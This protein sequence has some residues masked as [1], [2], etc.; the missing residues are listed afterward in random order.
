MRSERAAARL[1]RVARGLPAP[2]GRLRG[3]AER[4]QRDGDFDAASK[5]LYGEIPGLE[6]ELEEAAEAEQEASKDT[7]VKEEVGPDEIAD[8][9]GAWTG[10]PAGRLLEGETQKLLRTESELGK[11]LIGQSEVVQAAPTPY[12]VRAPGSPTPTGSPGRSSSSASPAS[13]RPSWPRRWRTSSST[14]SGP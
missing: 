5:L 6:R 12:A 4:A 7:M 3:Q 10:I 2:C 13:A 11:R 9:V 1:N 8:V 14:T